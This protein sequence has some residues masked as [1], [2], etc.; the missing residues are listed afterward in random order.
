MPRP[1][2]TLFAFFIP[3]ITAAEKPPTIPALLPNWSAVQPIH[4]AGRTLLLLDSPD[5][6]ALRGFTAQ[7][8]ETRESTPQV[9]GSPTNA[10]PSKHYVDFTLDWLNREP[11]TNFQR[12]VDPVTGIVRSRCQLGNAKVTRTVL[13]DPN[14]G[15]VFI[16][17]LAN[18]PGALSFRAS[19]TTSE[20]A[21]P[22]LEDRRELVISSAD[23]LSAHLRVV[24]F[25]S[26]VAPDGNSIVVRGEGEALIVLSYATGRNAPKLLAETWKSLADRHDAG[27]IPPD[28]T[29]I[30]HGVLT[31]RLKSDE[32]SP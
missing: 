12:S 28:P 2:L 4:A 32:N 14:D 16:H 22:R 18:L 1:L 11:A 20:S 30:W 29:R 5:R 3:V 21:A 24:P 27:N 13:V 26:D 10:P 25:E 9:A 19:L 15:T 6:T 23:T 31:Q 17:L 7:S 8:K